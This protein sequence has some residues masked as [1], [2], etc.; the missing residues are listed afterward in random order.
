MRLFKFHLL[1][2][3]VRVCDTDVVGGHFDDD[4]VRSGG[5]RDVVLEGRDGVVEP[6]L[7][8]IVGRGDRGT[9][10]LVLIPGQA[11]HGPYADFAAVGGSKHTAI[12]V[13]REILYLLTIHS[14]SPFSALLM[15]I[16]GLYRNNEKRK[17]QKKWLGVGIRAKRGLGT[18]TFYRFFSAVLSCL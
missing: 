7:F 3:K 18:K 12:D 15:K 8:G 9:P 1:I 16:G 5:G 2:G 4:I 6:E 17:G 14:F 10:E 11:G 13:F